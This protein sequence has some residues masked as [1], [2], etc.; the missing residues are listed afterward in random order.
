MTFTDV[1]VRLKWQNAAKL[2]KG[3]GT[4]SRSAHLDGAPATIQDRDKLWA[5]LRE[6]EK[7]LPE[8]D[9]ARE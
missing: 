1:D 4:S 2:M 9:D 3:D 7:I 8:N 5:S 6:R